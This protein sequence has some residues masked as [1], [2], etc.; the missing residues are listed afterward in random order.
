MLQIKSYIVVTAMQ[1]PS[2]ADGPIRLVVPCD[3]RPA[4][5]VRMLTKLEIETVQ[6]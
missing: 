5:W 3:K 6:P 1:P 2:A 4:R